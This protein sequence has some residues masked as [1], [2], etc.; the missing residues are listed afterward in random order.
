MG[1]PATETHLIAIIRRFDLDADAK[2][3]KSEFS[4]GIAPLLDYSKRQVK[5]KILRPS[6][7]NRELALSPGRVPETSVAAMRHTARPQ[8]AARGPRW[9][10]T[11]DLDESKTS[12]VGP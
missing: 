1:V 12:P 9:H 11:N 8:T 3:T 10:T 6:V 5:E 2:L 7:N 4:Q